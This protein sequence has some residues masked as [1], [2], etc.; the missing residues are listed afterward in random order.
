[1]PVSHLKKEP[2]VSF[3]TNIIQSLSLQT[4]NYNTEQGFHYP[5]K[6]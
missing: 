5:F 4:V 2:E 1:M 6:P 3:I